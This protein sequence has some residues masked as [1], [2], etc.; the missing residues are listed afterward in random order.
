MSELY[1]AK[2]VSRWGEKGM[3]VFKQGQRC[4]PII[5]LDEQDIK[6]FQEELKK[7]WIEK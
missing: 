5:F 7:E 6:Q 2:Y 3:L 4:T 1:F